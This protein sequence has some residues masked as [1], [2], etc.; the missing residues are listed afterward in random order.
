MMLL[1]ENPAD[2]YISIGDLTNTGREDEFRGIFNIMKQFPQYDLFKMV[3]GNHDLYDMNMDVVEKIIP[4]P[5]NYYIVEEDTCLIFL[6][7]SINDTE[8]SYG[9]RVLM[10]EHGGQLSKEQLD[11]LDNL[12]TLHHDKKLV[13]FAHHPLYDTTYLSTK[14]YAYVRETEQVLNILEKHQLPS[15]YINGHKHADSIVQKNNW[16]FIQ[17]ADVINQPTVRDIEITDKHFNLT[18]R[19]LDPYYAQIGRFIGTKMHDVYH[20]N[21]YAYQGES[22]RHLTIPFKQ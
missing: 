16:T 2:Y 15:F 13:I 14:I 11:W 17:I 4:T 5:L 20:L 7:T 8:A 12:V 6:N 3:I 22:E 9:A 21:H 1:F 19:E 10:L 18:Y